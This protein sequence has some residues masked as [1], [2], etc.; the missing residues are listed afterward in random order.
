MIHKHYMLLLSCG[1][2]SLLLFQ[3]HAHA[4]IDPGSG[5][6]LFQIMLAGLVGAAFALK[7]CWLKIK[8][9]LKRISHRD[10]V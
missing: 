6:Y 4:Y 10:T 1:S 9:F 5:S 8:N 2:L 3:E 7:S